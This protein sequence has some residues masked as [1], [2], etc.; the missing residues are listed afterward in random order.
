MGT[1]VPPQHPLRQLFGALT[2]RSFTEHLGWPDLNVAGYVSNLL[3][4][5]THTDQLYKIRTAQDQP[6]DTV[7]DL[8]FESEVVLDAQS[9][10]R[11]REVHRH[12]GDFTLFMENSQI[13]QLQK[14]PEMD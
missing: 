2:E 8:L 13:L 7:V 9:F 12:I 1:A 10:E 14:L 5:F 6:V 4:D 11:Q 3:V